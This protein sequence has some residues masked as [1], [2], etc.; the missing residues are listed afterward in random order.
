[1]KNWQENGFRTWKSDKFRW[2]WC[3]FENDIFQGDR[4]LALTLQF[5]R[6]VFQ[7]TLWV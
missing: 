5:G 7:L 3:R 6:R 1:M 2:A 4:R